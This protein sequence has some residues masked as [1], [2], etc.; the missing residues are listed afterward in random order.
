MSSESLVKAPYW[1]YMDRPADAEGLAHWSGLLDSGASVGDVARG[2]GLSRESAD[3]NPGI[4]AEEVGRFGRFLE[5]VYDRLFD[6]PYEISGLEYWGSRHLDGTPAV[7]I[8][9][10][11][12]TSAQGHDA[13]VLAMKVSVVGM[14]SHDQTAW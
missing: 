9:A 3:H 12:A 1:G 2:I 5:T 8:V 11:V 10:Q 6:R 14:L 4:V 7:D 13:E